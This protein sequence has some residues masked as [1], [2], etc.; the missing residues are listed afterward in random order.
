MRE[1]WRILRCMAKRSSGG[2]TT[3]CMFCK[4][5]G[6]QLTKEDVIPLWLLR[7]LRPW[8][9]K[10]YIGIGST[11]SGIRRV[12]KRPTVR[13]GGICEDCNNGWMHDLERSFRALMIPAITGEARKP[14]LALRLD[15]GG[16]EVVATWTAK[17]MLLMGYA[18]EGKGGLHAQGFIEYL[19]QHQRPPGT[20]MIGIG[21]ADLGDLML[22]HR[23]SSTRRGGEVIAITS[24]LAI[25]QLALYFTMVVRQASGER[26][27]AMPTSQLAE[28]LLKIWPSQRPE[29]EWPPP[30]VLT[31]EDIERFFPHRGTDL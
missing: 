5:T 22:V 29:V 31:R 12:A 23:I 21:V 9:D 3:P 18:M 1:R 19:Y 28:S 2:S 14:G 16:Q 7:M 25:G 15:L 4:R 24:L 11:N 17:T 20:L 10:H 26:G 27:F 6:V 13:L 30:R 8:S